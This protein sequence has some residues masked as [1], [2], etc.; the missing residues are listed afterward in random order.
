MT[1]MI[2]CWVFSLGFLKGAQKYERGMQRE[3]LMMIKMDM[4]TER[5]TDFKMTRSVLSAYFDNYVGNLTGDR[6]LKST[7]NDSLKKKRNALIT[8]SQE[9]HQYITIKDRLSKTH[10]A[11]RDSAIN[12]DGLVIDETQ[13]KIGKDF[14]DLF[15]KKWDSPKHLLNYSIVVKEKPIP[16]L[17]TRIIVEINGKIIFQDFLQPRYEV[18]E[19][20]ANNAVYYAKE[21]LRLNNKSNFK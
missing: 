7:S 18:V 19:Q 21:F 6:Y 20:A 12:F 1:Y 8:Y 11:F 15:Y 10:T 2:L 9:W 5:K 4:N 13:S 3:K 17:G 14:Y 16:S